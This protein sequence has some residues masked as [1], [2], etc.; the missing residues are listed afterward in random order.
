MSRGAFIS[1]LGLYEANPNIFDDFVLPTYTTEHEEDDGNGNMVIVTETHDYL[2]RDNF[3]NSLLM[4]CAE[5]ELIYTDADFMK[6][7]MGVW[8]NKRLHT[9]GKYARVLYEDYNPFINIKRHET[10][11]ISQDRDLSNG[12]T[13]NV[14]AWDD[15][16]DDGVLRNKQ[17]GT[18]T[19]NVTTTENYDLEGDSAITD[20]QDVA[21]K[22][23]E[24]RRAYDLCDLII[25]EFKQRFC[26]LVY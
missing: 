11:I 19:G 20:A 10:R 13:V 8:S 25:K 12:L 16:S 9:W 3:I 6:F 22:E 21:R 18:D 15:S 5:I 2:D 1:I 23:I 4:D 14:N 26:L 17:T 24:L 7:A